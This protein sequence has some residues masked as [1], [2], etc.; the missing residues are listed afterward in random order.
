MAWNDYKN[1]LND[2]TNIG[3]SLKYNAVEIKFLLKFR[4][5]DIEIITVESLELNEKHS[6]KLIVNG[7]IK[8]FLNYDNT[9]RTPDDSYAVYDSKSLMME[10]IVVWYKLKQVLQTKY[11]KNLDSI[12]TTLARVDKFFV[13]KEEFLV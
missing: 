5:N 9:L 12:E 11:K 7:T 10:D 13:G 6:N 1:A 4:Q 3:Q 2:N 8:F